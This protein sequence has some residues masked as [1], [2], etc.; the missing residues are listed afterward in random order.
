MSNQNSN[1]EDQI[2]EIDLI[3]LKLNQLET[4]IDRQLDKSSQIKNIFTEDSP[5]LKTPKKNQQSKKDGLSRSPQIKEANMEESYF[6][7]AKFT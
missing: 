7:L 3:N 4:I 2:S 5:F 1:M 6:K